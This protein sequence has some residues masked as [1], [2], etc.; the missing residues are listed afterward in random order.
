MSDVGWS[1]LAALCVVTAALLLPWGPAFT[2][3]RDEPC[4]V[5]GAPYV[6]PYEAW[7]VR[8]EQSLWPVG[9]TCHWTDLE[10]GGRTEQEPGWTVSALAAT[11]LVT[12]AA[13]G[14]VDLRAERRSHRR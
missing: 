3:G 8:A 1:A 7:Q 10:S 13:Y 12:A 9:V 2:N 11:G 4:L 14:F 6:P 5:R